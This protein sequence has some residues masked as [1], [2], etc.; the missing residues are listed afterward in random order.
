MSHGLIGRTTPTTPAPK[1]TT[2]TEDGKIAMIWIEDISAV[3]APIAF[4]Y[5]LVLGAVMMAP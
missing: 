1:G 3:L 2:W 5:T 4:I